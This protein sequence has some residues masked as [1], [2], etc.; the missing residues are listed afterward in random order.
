M[1]LAAPPSCGVVHACPPVFSAAC[2]VVGLGCLTPSS[3]CG[4]VV[5]FGLFKPPSPPPVVWCGV[6]LW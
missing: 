6:L 3:S 4:V 1:V 5:G 2:G